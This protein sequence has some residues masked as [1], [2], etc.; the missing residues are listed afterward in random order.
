MNTCTDCGAWAIDDGQ[1]IVH[2]PGCSAE[3]VP[4]GQPRTLADANAIQHGGDHYKKMG[5]EPWD[6]SILNDL[7]VFQSEVLY[8]V[9][10][11]KTK[12]GL[13]D[14]KKAQHWLA[15]YIEVETARKEHGPV[16]MKA[17]LL[18]A[19]ANKVEFGK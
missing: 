14:L 12:N 1:L 18:S 10:R 4:V 5:I 6:V 3:R 17:R 11:W 15:K 13:E 9:M 2:K 19:A 16:A 8:Y 7:D